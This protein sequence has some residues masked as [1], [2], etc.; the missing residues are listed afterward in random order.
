M[1]EGYKMRLWEKRE[2]K[3]IQEVFHPKLL[4]VLGRTACARCV[5]RK[6]LTREIQTD[7]RY[8]GRTVEAI[9]AKARRMGL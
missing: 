4:A 1:R 6:F 9:E 8:F 7:Y 2:L 3:V 5:R